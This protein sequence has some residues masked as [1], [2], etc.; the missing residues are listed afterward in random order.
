MTLTPEQRRFR[1]EQLLRNLRYTFPGLG[2]I[3]DSKLIEI[4]NDFAISE[5]YG[6][7]DERFL[8]FIQDCIDLD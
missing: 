2:N 4:Y 6:N 8:E 5:Y 7:N 3:T 1:D